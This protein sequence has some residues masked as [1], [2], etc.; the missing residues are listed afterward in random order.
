MRTA[1]KFLHLNGK[2]L[3]SRCRS[4]LTWTVFPQGFKNSPTL[5]GEQL[6]RD[7]QS[8]EAPPEEGKLLQYV[9]DLLTA[10]RMKEAC[11]A[12]TVSLL[13]F[14]GLQGYRVSKKKAQVVKQK[15][16]YLGYEICVAQQTL[17]Q[18]HKEAMC[19]TLKPQTVKE[20]RTLLGMTGWC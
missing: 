6:A 19:Q 16:I 12:W 15:V 13:N 17:G 10:T 5:L 1:R 4:Q 20:L 18:D 11:A 2:T 14:L 7:L 3:K 8:W 9:D